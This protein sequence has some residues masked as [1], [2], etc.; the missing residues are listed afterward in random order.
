MTRAPTH[1]IK[2]FGV[3]LNNK[4]IKKRFVKKQGKTDVTAMEVD[5]GT[6]MTLVEEAQKQ[7]TKKETKRRVQPTAEESLPSIADAPEG[8]EDE[9]KPKRPQKIV[10]GRIRTNDLPLVVNIK[11]KRL[12]NAKP[13][14]FSNATVFPT[15][16]MTKKQLRK[17]VNEARREE[18][19][20]ER[21]A[22]AM[23]TS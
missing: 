6:A 21:V 20:A 14:P 16:R 7:K 22:K 19:A 15:R 10:E 11:A 5:E 23:D 4:T 13:S 12:R 8:E 17:R 9:A 18:R 1:R 2:K 3:K